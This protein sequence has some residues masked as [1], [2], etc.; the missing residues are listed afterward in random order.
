MCS[1]CPSVRP[2]VP[3]LHLTREWRTL[4]NQKFWERLS[5]PRV[6]CGPILTSK[7]HKSTRWWERKNVPKR[8]N[9]RPHTAFKL[10]R[11]TEH[12]DTND[13]HCKAEGQM[14]RSKGQHIPCRLC[15]HWGYLLGNLQQKDHYRIHHTL[16]ASLHYLVKYQ[17]LI[18]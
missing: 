8:L 1:V 4:E 11:N 6:D 14:P 13:K 5:I 16:M 15:L 9:E 18:T 7:G 10:A 17:C 3:Y 2:F 12:V